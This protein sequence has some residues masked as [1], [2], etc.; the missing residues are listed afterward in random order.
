MPS[1]EQSRSAG[2]MKGKRSKNVAK[3]KTLLLAA[4][5]VSLTPS[6]SAFTV[7]PARGPAHVT[8]SSSTA[9][10][11]SSALA[12]S[13]ND[14]DYFFTRPPQSQDND[15]DDDDLDL[16][17]K[18]MTSSDSGI[19][20]AEQTE[21]ETMEI[22]EDE[23]EDEDEDVEE[24]LLSTSSVVASIP[25]TPSP[26]P[27]LSMDVD[28]NGTGALMKRSPA[29]GGVDPA[30]MATNPFLAY[31]I[32]SGKDGMQAHDTKERTRTPSNN[33]V[34]DIGQPKIRLVRYIL[35]TTDPL[36][37][38]QIPTGKKLVLAPVTNKSAMNSEL[39]RPQKSE[40]KSSQPRLV[41]YNGPDV[42]DATDFDGME[43]D[44]V[45]K[46]RNRELNLKRSNLVRYNGE[47]HQER[48]MEKP[49]EDDEIGKN[50][51][52]NDH[53]KGR[54]TLVEDPGYANRYAGP[55]DFNL[56]KKTGLAV[57]KPVGLWV[58]RDKFL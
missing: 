38:K 10:I 20:S 48:Y 16:E 58:E 5:C 40:A 52:E 54:K 57:N 55:S 7:G 9:Q 33:A 34:A 29:A 18:E 14:E 26:A 46:K 35:P 12:S 30:L 4:V 21:L 2:R 47:S 28:G 6:T 36:E 15:D 50:G 53:H 41:R 56:A 19:V 37:P 24:D 45:K 8:A 32:D 27:T 43:L 51:T 44:S 1:S 3:G 17:T 49:P 42:E 31:P 39:A 25:S 22:A 23:D 11:G 13:P